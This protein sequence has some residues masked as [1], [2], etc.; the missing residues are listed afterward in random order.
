M[1][2]VWTL[3]QQMT[4]LI[5]RGNNIMEINIRLNKNFTTAFNKMLNEY[6]EEMA[7][8]NGFSDEQLSYTDFIDNFVD[9]QTVADASIDGNANAGTKDICSL[10]AE[11][12]KPHS[13]LLA[14]NKIFYEMNKKYGFKVA[15]NWLKNEWDGHFYLHDAA[16]S[17]MKPYCFA[18]DIEKLIK[19]GLYFIDN[20]NAQPPKHLVTYT[21]FVGEFVS[22]TSNRT[23]GKNACRFASFPVITGVTFCS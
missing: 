3:K 9:K 10:E 22:W 21:D 2:K 13:K 11:M 14:F 19:E 18:Y 4:G 15:N 1:I 7:R 23:S 12:S 6:G 20:F 5:H 8:L 16:S 17:T